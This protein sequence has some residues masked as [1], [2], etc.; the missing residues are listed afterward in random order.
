MA[1]KKISTASGTTMMMIVRNWRFRNASAPS[2]IALAIS[3][4]FAEPV[5][6]ASTPRMSTRPA[7]MPIT[8][9]ANAS[10]SQTQSALWSW[11]AW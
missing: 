11:K 5:S 7:T 9:A 8:P 2:W 10:T 6:A 3:R 1:V 4:I